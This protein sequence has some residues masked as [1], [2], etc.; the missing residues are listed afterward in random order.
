MMLKPG[1]ILEDSK[2]CLLTKHINMDPDKNG[3]IKLFKQN[4]ITT[5]ILI[6]QISSIT[7]H[8]Q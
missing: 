1:A 2:I 7:K 4:L 8:Q 6:E 5:V 3:S